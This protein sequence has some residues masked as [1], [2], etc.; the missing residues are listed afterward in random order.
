[1]LGGLPASR[2][3]NYSYLYVI[4][5]IRSVILTADIVDYQVSYREKHLRLALHKNKTESDLDQSPG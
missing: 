2:R 5:V 4:G 1:M 3:G